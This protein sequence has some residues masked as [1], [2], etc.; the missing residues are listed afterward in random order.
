[1]KKLLIA[2]EGIDGSGKYVQSIHTKKWLCEK[3]YIAGFSSEPNDDELGGSPLGRTIRKMLKGKLKKPSPLE[4][5]RIYIADRFQDSV[6]FITPF[7]E[8]DDKPRAYVIERFKMSTF[9]YG[10]LSG[11]SPEIIQKMH[12]DVGGIQIPEPDIYIYIDITPE[13]ALRRI[14]SRRIPNQ[15]F[16]KKDLL[17]KVRE[18]YLFLSQHPIFKDRTIFINGEQTK[19]K[20]FEDIKFSL[21]PFLF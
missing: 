9:A 21:T 2:F 7:L 1:M 18:N 16:E 5:Q 13:E 11:A 3:G 20:V 8:K 6:C 17:S 4:F 15:D 10:M 14:E 19:E 12:D